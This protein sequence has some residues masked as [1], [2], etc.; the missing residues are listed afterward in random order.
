VVVLLDPFRD[1]VAGLGLGG[2]VLE[3]AE[4]ELHGGVPALDDR[5]V[6]RGPDP[7]R[8]LG[9]PKPAAGGLVGSRGVR[10]PGRSGTPLRP[11]PASRPGP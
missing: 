4:L 2:E 9:D 7:A 5:V 1:P 6:E 10:C 3:H 11:P 8:G